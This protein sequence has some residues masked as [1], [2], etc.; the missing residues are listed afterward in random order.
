LPS[1]SIEPAL[2]YFHSRLANMIQARLRKIFMAATAWS[3][4]S[5]LKKEIPSIIVSYTEKFVNG[6][7]TCQRL[8]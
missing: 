5:R 1:K 7:P 4:M 3:T 8:K 2:G 6:L